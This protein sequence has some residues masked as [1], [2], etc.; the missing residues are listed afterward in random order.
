M[1]TLLITPCAPLSF[2]VAV[3]VHKALPYNLYHIDAIKF[4]NEGTEDAQMVLCYLLD[5]Q[6]SKAA[7]KALAFKLEE[8]FGMEFAITHE[9]VAKQ[10]AV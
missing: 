7:V 6:M 5:K 1:H 8:Q 9:L 10:A 4:D 3:D 2:Q